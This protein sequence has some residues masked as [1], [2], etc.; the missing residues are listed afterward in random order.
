MTVLFFKGF[1]MV[2][3]RFSFLLC[4]LVAGCGSAQNDVG[5]ADD[6]VVNN[7][8]G[9]EMEAAITEARESIDTFT[10]ALAAKS[11]SGF[12]VKAPITDSNGTEHFWLV[13]VRIEDGV[14]SGRINNDPGIVK[15]VSNG[16]AWS[17][18]SGEIS[19]WLFMRDGKMHGNYTLRP[20]MKTMPPEEA[21]KLRS[22]LAEP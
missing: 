5:I 12:A 2:V 16:Q 8:D 20:L 18:K 21:A 15:N 9:D 14:F 6:P 11:G 7:F 22:I 4:V 3:P 19:D 1:L 10:E 17:V 13:D